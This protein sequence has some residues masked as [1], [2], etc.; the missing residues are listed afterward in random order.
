VIS[1]SS[2]WTTQSAKRQRRPLW[3]VEID[4]YRYAFTNRKGVTFPDPAVLNTP[5]SRVRS[6]RRP[7]GELVLLG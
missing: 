5:S 2:A 4:T 7:A 3:L 6:N 1:P